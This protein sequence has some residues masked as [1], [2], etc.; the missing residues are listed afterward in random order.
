MNRRKSRPQ[1][2]KMLAMLLVLPIAVWG[3]WRAMPTLMQI[4]A[5]AAMVSAYCNMPEGSLA[6]LEERFNSEL[7]GQSE[8]ENPTVPKKPDITYDSPPLSEDEES[9]PDPEP[10]EEELVER[11]I[12]PQYR[13]IIKELQYGADL[14]L[15]YIPLAAGHLKNTTKLKNEQ[16]QKELDKPLELG[17]TQT[18][19]PQVLIVH[20]HATEAYEPV[21]S[22]SYDTRGTWRDTDNTNNMVQVGNRIADELTAKGIGVIHD[23]TQHDYPTYNGAYER[24]AKTVQGWL[25]KYPSIKVVLDVHRDAIQ[26]EDDTIVKAVAI[27]DGRK[28][29]QVMIITGC[30]DG[31]MNVPDWA[32]NLRF[33][34]SLQSTAEAKY[35]GLMRPIFFCYRKYNMDLTRG[36]I[37]LEF[38]SHGNTLK[39]AEYSGELIG[40][41][42]A[43]LLETQRNE[44]TK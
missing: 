41:A 2:K 40:K 13:G 20:T 25:E 1:A 8:K 19:E 36:S 7:F 9:V 24:S 22:E 31:T 33:A 37:L 28:A 12:P 16:V 35:E 34:A 30:D 15:P 6:V 11:D 5:K 10:Y 29:A 42:L 44:N 43:E 23:D 3:T 17:I 27:I 32:Y 26:P 38:G 21:N 18:D 14:T 39:E 4:A